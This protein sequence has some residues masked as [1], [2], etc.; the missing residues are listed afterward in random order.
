MPVYGPEM[1][2]KERSLFLPWV[3]VVGAPGREGWRNM[4]EGRKEAPRGKALVGGAGSK[5]G[6]TEFWGSRESAGS[7]PSDP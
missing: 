4:E 6:D 2:Q 3:Y 5:W 7:C 1:S